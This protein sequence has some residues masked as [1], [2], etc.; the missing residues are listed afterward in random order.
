MSTTFRRLACALALAAL[1]A[2]GGGGNSSSAGSDSVGGG[3]GGA[4]TS[5]TLAFTTANAGR[6][7]GYPLWASE[8]MLRIGQAVSE[9]VAAAARQSGAMV[10][11]VQC[12]SG[13]LQRSWA[14]KDGNGTL[15]A[16]DEI[17]LDFSACAREPMARSAQGRITVA[18][19]S[20]T[21]GG[22]FVARVVLPAPGLVLA[23]VVGT[24]GPTDFRVSG[25]TRMELARNYLR[26][27]LLIGGGSDDAIAFEF[28]GAGFAADRI[29][30]FRLN[31]THR[32]DEARTQLDIRMHYDSPEL[33]GSFE[34]SMPMPLLSWLDELPEPDVQQGSFEMRGRGGDLVSVTIGSASLGPSDL[35]VTLDLAGNGSVDA[36]GQGTWERAGLVSGVFFADYTAGGLGNTYAYSASEFTLRAPLVGGSELPVDTAFSLQFTRPVA[37]AAAWRWR[38][39]DQGRLDQAPSAGTEVPVQAELNGAL[40]TLKPAQ[41]LRYSHRYELVVDT[42][43]PTASGQLMRATTGGTLSR[44]NG[45]IGA[46]TTPNILNPQSSLAGHLTLTVGATVEAVGVPPPSGAPEGIRYQWTQLGGTPLTIFKANERSSLIALAPGASGVGSATVRLTVSVDGAGNSESADFVL[47]TVADTSGAW[48][49]RLRVPMDLSNWLGPPEELWSGPAVGTL[50]ARQQG[51]RLSLTYAESADPTHPNGNWNLELI[52]AD[53]QALRPGIYANAFSSGWFQRPAGVPTLDLVSGQIRPSSV[54]GEFIIHELAVDG[55]GNV[56]KLALDFTAPQGSGPVTTSGAV[57][58]NSALALPQ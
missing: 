41:P 37:G 8:L 22:D 7:A 33:G 31:K 58:I 25:Q 4:A 10:T 17:T 2:C 44:Y 29:T 19:D 11:T 9:E 26:H 49:S 55:A 14:D 6:V 54:Q 38:L 46:F 24:P 3:T 47:R 18:L 34:V 21:S 1:S 40:I 36:R 13:T 20:A 45:S 12:P 57:R 56:T 48:I 5:T 27:T 53:G 50:T 15:G 42:G 30:A 51:D 28:P 32:W 23:A 52:S 43:E 35:S 16:G 39:L